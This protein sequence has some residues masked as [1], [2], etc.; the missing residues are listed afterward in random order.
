M[1]LREYKAK[2]DFTRTA[3]PPP[4]KKTTGTKRMFVIQKHDASR[5]HYD[6]RLEMD[7]VLKSW[8]VPKGVPAAKGDKRLAVHV[9]DHPMD[10]AK[11]EGI[12]PAGQYGGGT[13]MVWDLGTYEVFGENPARDVEKGKLHFVLRGTKLDGEWALVK[14]TRSEKDEWLL[15]KS[16]ADM[17]PISAKRDDQSVLSKRSMKQIAAA[18]DAEWQSNRAEEKSGKQELRKRIQEKLKAQETTPPKLKSSRKSEIESRKFKTFPPTK[19]KFVEPMK[20]KLAETPPASGDWLYELKF[21][22]FRAL[23]IKNGSDVELIS[24]NEK[25]LTRKFPDVARAVAELHP[26]AAVFDGE[27]VALDDQGRSSFQLLQAYELNEERPPICYY[28]FDLPILEGHDLRKLPLAERKAALRSEVED[29]D[30]IRFSS[31]IEGDPQKLLAEVKK[32]GLEGII[33]KRKDSVYESGSRSGAWIKL[34][35]LNEQEFVIGGYTAPQGARKFFGALVVGF[36][37]KDKLMFAAKVGTG[38][39]D[40]L[41]RELHKTFQPLRRDNCPFVNLPTKSSTRNGISRAEMRR[42]TWVEPK[43]V[44]QVRFTEWTRDAGLRHPAFLG[45]REDKSA[46]DVVRETPGT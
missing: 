36:Y 13:V 21:D 4:V 46:R 35:A 45:L 31:N 33:G 29:N 17:K 7:G 41:L 30:V 2:R 37:E 39:S 20:A 19:P 6:F 44:A 34:K 16:G 25:S 27:I 11:F 14:I 26:D 3:E 9:E 18:R 5:L 43:L 32:R 10:Y 15:I 42:C 1:G 23:A 24:R 28:V 38:F 12:I 22:G 8:A 40:K